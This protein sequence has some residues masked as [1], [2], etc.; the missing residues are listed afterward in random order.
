M[1][2]HTAYKVHFPEVFRCS[3]DCKCGQSII[4][5]D[6]WERNLGPDSN[7]KPVLRFPRI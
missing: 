6:L 3:Y 1:N 7:S 5:K 4:P 2:L